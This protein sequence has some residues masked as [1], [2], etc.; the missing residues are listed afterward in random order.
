MTSIFLLSDGID[1][2]DNAL[3]ESRNLF[4]KAQIEKNF[5]LHTFGY[6]KNH[7][8]ELMRGLSESFKGNFYYV[9][10]VEDIK[11]CFI[12]CLNEIEN[13]AVTDIRVDFKLNP[14][15]PFFNPLQ[16]KLNQYSG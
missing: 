4:R 13:V 5:S 6:G 2:D 11:Q 8:S 15:I 10:N 1:E 9:E 7:D 16:I 3:E 14:M 12:D